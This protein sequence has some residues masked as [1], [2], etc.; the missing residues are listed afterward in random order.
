MKI[1]ATEPN[2]SQKLQT[3]SLLHTIP[4]LLT[5]WNWVNVWVNSDIVL[6]M[7]QFIK[8][9]AMIIQL[10]LFSGFIAEQR[11]GCGSMGR[12]GRPLIVLTPGSYGVEM[13]LSKKRKSRQMLHRWCELVIVRN[14]LKYFNGSDDAVILIF[15]CD[16]HAP[17]FSIVAHIFQSM[18]K[19]VQ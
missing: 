18:K 4:F 14:I 13:S 7:C 17:S 5:C 9:I 3:F 6:K 8:K 19:S 10:N 11:D 16:W 12:P 2:K 1:P 15:Y